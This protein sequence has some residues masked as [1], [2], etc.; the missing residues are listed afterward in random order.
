MT[1]M[2]SRVADE[3]RE[4]QTREVLAMTPGE[5]VELA[6]RLGDEAV[7]TFAAARGLTHDEA[8]RALQREGQR[9]RRYSRCIEELDAEPPR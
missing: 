4:A 7:A 8:R 1:G 5:R 2:K 6:L 3:V 9:G